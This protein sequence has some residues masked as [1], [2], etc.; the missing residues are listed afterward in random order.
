MIDEYGRPIILFDPEETK[1]RIKGK[2]AYKVNNLIN[3]F[4]IISWQLEESLQFLEP[5]LDP[6]EWIKCLSGI[7]YLFS[8]QK[9]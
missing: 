3:K 7:S 1:K 6:R 8:Y 9:I 4:S 5:L 2:E